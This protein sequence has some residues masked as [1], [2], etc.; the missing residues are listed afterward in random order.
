M[1]TPVC[2]VSFAT[3]SAVVWWLNLWM[4]MGHHRYFTRGISMG[5][6]IDM[7]PDMSKGGVAKIPMALPSGKHPSCVLVKVVNTFQ[8]LKKRFGKIDLT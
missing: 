3:L 8:C 4:V 1:E 6:R 7:R 5:A 2:L